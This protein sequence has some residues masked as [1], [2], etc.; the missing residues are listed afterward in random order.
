MRSIPAHSS[1]R[2]A[3]T[4]AA[5]TSLVRCAG[6]ASAA[7]LALG[8]AAAPQ[9]H[10][11]G[12][13]L[14]GTAGMHTDRVY[15]YSNVDSDTFEDDNPVVYE[16]FTDFE[17]FAVDQNLLHGG[18]GAEVVLGDRDDL[19][20]GS[21]RLL[22][23]QDAPQQDPASITS[24]VP[25]EYI[26]TA[27]RETPRHLGIGLIGLNWGIVDFANDRFR[28]EAVGLVGSAFITTDHTEFFTAGIG[29]GIVYK[30]A[31][32]AHVF[33]EMTYFARFQQRLGLNHSANFTGG[34]RYY[35]D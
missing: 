16:D 1:P 28:F 33:A 14:L 35:F 11:G 3:A 29:P 27:Y 26:V 7:V 2:P 5:P 20:T 4:A 12:L 10:A 23:V 15:F 6:R 8:L 18:G 25:E 32:Q 21:V 9:A 17:Q 31:R 30:A 34:V 22:Y 13:S 24:A 19:I